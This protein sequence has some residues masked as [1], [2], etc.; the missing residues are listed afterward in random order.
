MTTRRW[1]SVWTRGRRVV[2]GTLEWAWLLALAVLRLGASFVFAGLGLLLFVFL[3][4]RVFKGT[5]QALDERVIRLFHDYQPAWLHEPVLLLTRLANGETI[6]IVGALAIG[7]FTVRR[8]YGT[9]ATVAIT[10]VGGWGLVEGLKALFDR[11]RPELRVL[12]EPG[13]SFPSGHAFFSLT[14][15]G[16]LAYLLAREAPWGRKRAVWTGVIVLAFLVGMSR[17]LLGVHYPSDVAAGFCAAAFWLWGCLKLPDLLDWRTWGE[18]RNGRLNELAFAREE[19]RALAPAAPEILAE[20]ERS[21][22]SATGWKRRALQGSLAVGHGYDRVA[23]RWPSLRKRP[24][25]VLPVAMALAWA[26][27]PEA[28]E[29]ARRLGIAG[30]VLLKGKRPK[31]AQE[32]FPPLP[33]GDSTPKA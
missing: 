6:A 9:A 1:Q 30:Q 26:D 33:A 14:L 5:T 17:M 20:A 29:A 12:D 4:H 10:L 18:W 24:F 7:Y 11:P 2:G 23:R 8:R 28:S 21:L 15:Y 16:L 31:P 27:A 3:A 19:F 25:G 13:L 32:P 22:P